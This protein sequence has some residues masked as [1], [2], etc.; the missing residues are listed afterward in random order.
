MS[1]DKLIDLWSD[2][3]LDRALTALHAPDA[4]PDHA[5]LAEARAQLMTAAG[6]SAE[7][8]VRRP[9]VAASP[10]DRTS[11]AAPPV[12]RRRWVYGLAAAAS[13]AALVG[14]GVI[15]TSST[16]GGSAEAKAELGAAADHIT[17]KDPVVPAGKYLH[18]TARGWNEGLI[19]GDG[20]N[21]RVLQETVDETWIPAD[22]KAEWVLRRTETGRH[23]WVT[24]SEEE[25]REHGVKFPVATDTERADCGGFYGAGCDRTG[26]WNDPTPSWIAGLPKDP[27]ALYQRLKKDAPRNGRGETELLVYARDALQTGLLPADVRARLYRALGYLNDLEISDRAANLDGRSGIAYGS[28]D[29]EFRQEIII[30]PA[31]GAYIGERQVDTDGKGKGDVVSWTSMSTNVVGS[32]PRR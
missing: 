29:G 23:Q 13:V 30:D 11:V 6:E 4:E 17:A 7:S 14:T 28:D 32:A 9:S 10:V 15:V 27:K 19:S 31:T 24:G 3:D 25:G 16:Q 8:S 20:W 18:R 1:D 22:K 12:R 2:D 5:R 26:D 21:F